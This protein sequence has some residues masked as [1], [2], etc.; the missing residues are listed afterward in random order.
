MNGGEQGIAMLIG[1]A[2][3]LP[4]ELVARAPTSPGRSAG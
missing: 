2:D 4:R 3:G 1:G